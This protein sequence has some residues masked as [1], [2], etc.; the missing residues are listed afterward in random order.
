MAELENDKQ[1][2]AILQARCGRGYSQTAPF[3]HTDGL[4]IARGLISTLSRSF[5]PHLRAQSG[6]HAGAVYLSASR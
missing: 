1:T 5:E 4:A 6:S 2:A 3:E